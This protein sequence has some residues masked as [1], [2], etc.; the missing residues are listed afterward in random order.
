M[1][2]D[3]GVKCTSILIK[4]TTTATRTCA[5]FENDKV[6]GYPQICSNPPRSLF[7]TSD[8]VQV[9]TNSSPIPFSRGLFY[10]AV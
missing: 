1:I 2:T 4:T 10:Y 3:T 7:R 8:K 6:T 5:K 9:L